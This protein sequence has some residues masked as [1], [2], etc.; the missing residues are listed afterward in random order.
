MNWIQ[1]AARHIDTNGVVWRYYNKPTHPLP[2]PE[3]SRWIPLNQEFP[4]FRDRSQFFIEI[5]IRKQKVKEQREEELWKKEQEKRERERLE[6]FKRYEILEEDRGRLQREEGRK[7]LLTCVE[8]SRAVM[9]VNRMQKNGWVKLRTG[10]WKHESKGN[11]IK[12][13]FR[14]HETNIHKFF[15]EA[16]FRKPR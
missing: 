8:A 14:S 4:K 10:T 12:I 11:L 13:I 6:E 2:P 3:G 15:I 7:K 1:F 9:V 16:H 5:Q